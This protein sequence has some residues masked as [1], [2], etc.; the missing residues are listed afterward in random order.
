MQLRPSIT[1]IYIYIYD[2]CCC[3][4]LNSNKSACKSQSQHL[5]ILYHIIA[6]SLCKS[7]MVVF[8]GIHLQSTECI[9]FCVITF[10]NERQLIKWN[11]NVN[12][13]V[14]WSYFIF[15]FFFPHAYLLILASITTPSK[16]SSSVYINRKEKE[17]IE[18][19]VFAVGE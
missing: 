17:E 6:F 11:E 18:I 3:E 19:P 14:F 1:V 2:C 4:T 5:F 12:C 15:F 10:L 8:R 13:N 7:S 9:L 16:L